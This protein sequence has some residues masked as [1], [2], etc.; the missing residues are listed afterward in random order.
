[1]VSRKVL[2]G[3][4]MASLIASSLVVGGCKRRVTEVTSPWPNADKER[5]VPEPPHVL[6]WPFTGKRAP[7][8][9]AIEKRPLSIKIENSSLSRPQ[10]G[11]NSADVV[12]ETISEGGIT[13]FNCIFHSTIPRRIGPVRSARM[14]DRYI[15][16]QY[17]ALF[18]YSGA[19]TLVNTRLSR[20]K[21]LPNL[22]QDAGVSAPYSRSSSRPSPHNLYMDTT[23]AY[24]TAK[25]RK[26]AVTARVEPL[27]FDQRAKEGTVTIS[28]LSVPFSPA[29][30]VR[31]NYRS[32][33]YYRYNNGAAHIDAATGKQVSANNV[34]VMWARYIRVGHDRVGSATFDI[35]LVGK[36]RASVFRNGTK[37][38]GTW[39]ADA[40]SPP[41]FKDAKGRAIRLT[42][43]RTW[44]QVLPPN[45][46][47]TM[48]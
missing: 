26:Y 19:S 37:L 23:K 42:P 40:D 43:G 18:F 8:A 7:S 36:G 24:D 10:T 16:P 47:I 5:V 45:G 4:L 12:Y 29:N 25:A 20:T 35:E 41:S 9:G 15:V 17:R 1:M 31:W 30:T 33:Q 32:G 46:L 11:L 6:L 34:V 14:S 3:V 2:I 27:R 28:E 13:R 21:N 48:K 38:D 39:T 22:S 44:F